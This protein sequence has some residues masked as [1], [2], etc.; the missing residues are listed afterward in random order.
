M[1]PSS[2]DIK[3]VLGHLTGAEEEV[4][5]AFL[6]AVNSRTPEEDSSTDDVLMEMPELYDHCL[7]T[8]CSPLPSPKVTG[9]CHDLRWLW[10]KQGERTDEE[11]AFQ[12]RF[13]ELGTSLHDLL[14]LRKLLSILQQKAEEHMVVDMPS[15]H[16]SGEQGVALEYSEGRTLELQDHRKIVCG[17][18]AAN[19]KVTRYFVCSDYWL[20]LVQPAVSAAGKAA[21]VTTRWPL[22][23]TDVSSESEAESARTL[24]VT[25]RSLMKFLPQRGA[26]A[27]SPRSNTIALNFEDAQHCRAARDHVQRRRRELTH[28]V[29]RQLLTVFLP[30]HVAE[31]Q[32][33]GKGSTV[34]HDDPEMS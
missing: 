27:T 31:N 2:D 15:I 28:E 23:L 34:E 26:T 11:S 12:E 6:Q 32:E 25:L 33:T 17:V 30:K 10:L 1:Q 16:L 24:H 7:S 8:A 9:I 29:R 19:G 5:N 18:S 13:G 3:V 22:R 21:T 20:L 14:V 4:S